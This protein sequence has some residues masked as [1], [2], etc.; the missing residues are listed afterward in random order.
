MN[1]SSF[2][3]YSALMPNLVARSRQASISQLGFSCVPLRHHLRDLFSLPY[4][5]SGALLA[6]PSFEA[7][8]GWESANKQMGEL[9]NKLLTKEL[10]DAMDSAGEF[11]FG[12][13]YL[14]YSHQLKSWEILSKS[15]PQSLVVASGTG[16]GKT[17]C[18][19]VPILDHLTRLSK[20][21]GRL[22]GVRALFL[23]PL[24]ALINSQRDRLNAWTTPF[25]GDIRFCLYN[26][27]TPE[28]PE[29]T[30]VRFRSVSEVQDRKSL[31][32]QPPPILVTN[33]TMLEYMLIRTQD[34]PILKQSQGKL[35]WIVLDEAHTYIGSQ[36]AEVALLLRRVLNAF[37][38]EPRNVRFVAT[39]ATI[40]DPNGEAG[41]NLKRFLADVAGTDV[42]QVHLVSGQRQIPSIQEDIRDNHLSI[43]DIEK[44]DTGK[45]VSPDRYI[46]LCQHSDARRIR[47]LFTQSGKPLV[48]RLSEVCTSLYGPR[49]EYNAKKQNLALRWLDL[50]SGT[51]NT[52]KDRQ[53]GE[54]F[55]P[56][57]A[58]FFHQTLS[59]IW[60][61]ADPACTAKQKSILDNEN[62]H[63]GMIYLEP[64]KH[65]KCGS[66]VYELVNCDDCGNVYLQAGESNG[67][68]HHLQ[69]PH[70]LD[71]FELDREDDSNEEIG[72]EES[73]ATAIQ[74]HQHAVL[75]VNRSLNLVGPLTIDKTTRQITE[76]N[77][78][79]LTI[80]VQEDEGDG[81]HCPGCG[82]KE[83]AKHRL[84]RHGRLSASFLLGNILP[85]LLEFAPDGKS[86]LDHPYRGRRLLTFN[87]SRQGT[88]R[89]AA[90]LQQ[91]AERNRVRGLV[92]HLALQYGKGGKQE[93]V[94]QLEKEIADLEHA[95]QLAPNDTLLRL[96]D[97]KKIKLSQV[98][99][100]KAIPFDELAQALANQ[101]RD[102]RFMRAY[103]RRYAPDV[104][105]T[106]AGDV[107][108]ARM[109]L[110]REFGRRPK[111]AN[112]LETM[113]LVSTWYPALDKL[114]DVP[115]IVK[116]ASGF[117]LETWQS[118]LKICLDFFVRG[119]GSLSFPREWKSWLGMRFGQ[120]WLVPFDQEETGRNMRRW[121]SVQRG[122]HTSI[123]VRLLAYAINA[124][125]DTA[126]GKDRV[127]IILRAAWDILCKKGLLRL[128]ADGRMLPI[129]Q[130]AFKPMSRGYICPV[131]RRILDT[132]LKGITPYLPKIA[133]DATARCESYPIPLFPKAFADQSDELRRIYTVREWLATQKE[134]E[135]LHDKGV[136]SSLNDRVIELAP[137][138]T[139]A[140]H[141][142]Q[143]SARQLQ[144]Y[145]KAFQEGD[146]NLLSCST[147]M[148]MG[149]DIGGISL[150]AMNNVPPNPSNYLQRAGRAGRRQESRSVTMTLCKSNPHDQAV[151]SNSRWA[152]DSTLPVPKV[153]LDS[154][155]I[156]Q[157]HVQAHLLSWFLQTSLKGSDQEQL[158]LSCGAFFLSMEN[159]KSLAGRFS[160]WCR[161]LRTLCSEKLT[162]GLEH[163]LQHTVYEHTPHETIF[164]MA[165][166][167]MKQLSQSWRSEWENLDKDRIDIKTE[168][169]EN[170]P[171]YKA[172]SFHIKRLEDEYLLRELANRG[173]LP[174]YGF[175]GHITPFDNYTVSQ[176]KR[177]Q[178]AKDSGREDNLCRFREM[179]SRDLTF[180]LR[181]YAPGSQIVIDGVVY[182]SAGLTLNWHIPAD[183]EDVRE[184]QNLK[185]VWRCR[186]CGASGSTHSL[187]QARTC[188]EC[189][190]TISSEYVRE[191]IEPAGF[192]VDFYE[193]PTNDIDTQ[194]FIPVEQ[195]WIAL[196]TQWSPLPNPDLGRFR[197]SSRG[198]VFHQSRGANGAGYALCLEC[199]RAEPMQANDDLPEKFQ[200]PHRKLRRSKSD[201]PFCPG[202]ENS[203]KIKTGITLGHEAWTDVCE[204]QLKTEAGIWLNDKV[205]ANTL[206][207]ALRDAL[208]ELIGV[209]A[210]ELACDIK[211]VRMENGAKC[212]SI[213]L[214]DHNAAGYASSVARFIEPLFRSARNRLLCP[215]N[216]DSVCP[217]CVLD[218]DQRFAAEHMDRHQALHLLSEQW[219]NA[220]ALP[221]DYAYFGTSSRL[222]YLPLIEA[223]WQIVGD[224]TATELRFYVSGEPELWDIGPSPLRALAYQIA[225]RGTQVR[226]IMP[227][228]LLGQLDEADQQLLASMADSPHIAIFGVETAVACGNGWLLA[229]AIGEQSTSWACDTQASQL[230]NNEW[231]QQQQILVQAPVRAST[232]IELQAIKPSQL[233]PASIIQG[234]REIELHTHL[235]G[236][237]QGFGKRFWDCITQEHEP[238]QKRLSSADKITSLRYQ[239]RY[240]F[241]PL[242]VRLLYEILKSL[243]KRIGEARFQVT[244]LNIHTLACRSQTGYSRHPQRFLWSDWDDNAMRDDVLKTVFQNVGLDAQA[245]LLEPH[246]AAHG[247][248][249]EIGF[250]SGAKLVIR[251]DQGVSYWR[252][253]KTTAYNNRTFDFDQP[254]ASKQGKALLQR[255]AKLEGGQFPTQLFIKLI[256]QPKT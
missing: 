41:E 248:L 218:Y 131:T 38:V 31:R 185:F 191:F 17:E 163:I 209:Q 15:D 146:I 127:D 71:E 216:C 171:A 192:A 95:C 102:M 84:F 106:D 107:T 29:R 156:V 92:Y 22:I 46:T 9:E 93:D 243:R 251:L 183:Q 145:E 224:S 207:V 188:Q 37:G 77:E 21:Q 244:T 165:A 241:S 170:T 221:D 26:G 64:R 97:E 79:A 49:K 90:K 20:K 88:A 193:N 23:Y 75:I 108:L 4:G 35:E 101:D 137:F 65:C 44:I 100:P 198:H 234:D 6:D 180:A 74:R 68:L 172:I 212:Q 231:G 81:L 196:D 217:H 119:G 111:R 235:N 123:L 178:R 104:F 182:R 50:L 247:R 239:D 208:A 242:S 2:S 39:S 128:D 151:F 91:E 155:V 53:Q 253:A 232:E 189:G 138:F 113:G 54:C 51:R 141:S 42:G 157:R 69:P 226:I 236:S 116:E 256:E 161:R 132:A 109:F 214:F 162:K 195:P 30:S 87:D 255:Q 202:S 204:I 58:H 233:R 70:Q 1:T 83:S 130:L 133:T 105:D 174:A 126:Q 10:I 25:N 121:S 82:A 72:V 125:L 150:V 117:D 18:F 237:L 89:I 190:E 7:V 28:R 27:N 96:I 199:G 175:P 34:A 66:P 13:E 112:N 120:S 167:E 103:Y 8:F 197:Q 98:G 129:D 24:N 168:S 219:L 200:Q 114:T 45:E 78:G 186:H 187:E 19:M 194:S 5:D 249:L 57:R 222:E 225:A 223:I 147:T 184:V 245:Q 136:W 210:T 140:E 59:G 33:S 238:S 144:D 32:S 230:F 85:S 159:T 166:D 110:V 124:D 201:S 16:S 215:A 176:F 205:T 213:L 179:P 14:P 63:F 154:P 139:T 206:A 153:S 220:L 122:R 246:Q 135:D 149:I 254:E 240:L 252:I 173:F 158:K 12:R 47:Q 160:S 118:F 152:F 94:A 36:A 169:G 67:Y 134:I 181:E 43:D 228:T 115:Q 177:D 60:V 250:E 55:L 142:A 11:R 203:W 76:N 99:Q 56:L 229:E 86:P 52:D 164:D 62:W 48:A 73:E 211:P 143:Q 61:C 3:Y 40:G 227:H 148:E 80:Q